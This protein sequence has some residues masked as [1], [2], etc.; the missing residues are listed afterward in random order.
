MLTHDERA[1]DQCW[2]RRSQIPEAGSNLE[3]GHTQLGIERD[4]TR[5]KIS[6]SESFRSSLH[7]LE[8]LA[9]LEGDRWTTRCEPK[10]Q[11]EMDDTDRSGGGTPLLQSFDRGV[12]EKR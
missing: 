6:D 4:L 1:D 2:E 7:R 10:H 9:S 3:G 8:M 12:I 11:W 5:H